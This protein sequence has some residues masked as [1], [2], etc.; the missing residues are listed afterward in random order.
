MELQIPY[1]NAQIPIHIQDEKVLGIYQPNPVQIKKDEYDTV[2]QALEYPIDSPGLSEFVKDARDILIIVNDATR[3]TP[4]PKVLEILSDHIRAAEMSFIVATGNHRGPT[5]DEFRFIFGPFY[6]GYKDRIHVH[7]A[8]KDEDMVYLGTSQKGTELFVNR[9]GVEAHKLI[10]IGSVEPHYFAGFTGGRKSIL[11]GIAAYRTIEQ[12]HKHALLPQARLLE[13]SGNPVH[14]DLIDA[15]NIIK[16]KEI[17]SIQ[18]VL[19][20]KR[21]IYAATAGDIHTSFDAAID[22]AKEV[23]AVDVPE[24][25]DIVVSVAPYPMD[26]DLYQSQKA[27]ETGKLALN[28]DGIL[29]MVSQCRD[30]IG[31]ETFMEL[32][33]SAKNAHEV[34][35]RIQAGYVLGYHKA[36]KMAEVSLWAEMWAKT[37]L[38]PDVIQSVYMKPVD[39]LQTA[40]EAAI[41]KKGD[42]AKV[43]F[44]LDGSITVP[45]IR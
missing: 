6:E 14:E 38:S 39:D 45:I 25:A 10:I 30:G 27:L 9:L 24:K 44:L 21:R 31:D 4:T 12:N 29:I 41:K 20:R 22:S 17:F 8:S 33:T 18:M 36:A 32:L 5:E 11:P 15:L 3:P 37:D 26:I 23:Y 34:L 2:L 16:D 19:D 28:R 42:G 35:E 43:V 7:A 1:G 13:L 40:L